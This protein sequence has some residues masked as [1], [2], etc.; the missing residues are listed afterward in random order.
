MIAYIYRPKR[1]RNG[2]LV[3][4]RIWR[5]R[6]KL[7][8]DVK[9]RDISL[10][11]ADKQTAEQKLRDSIRDQE[12]ESVGLLA[13]S[14]QRKTFQSPLAELVGGYVADLKALGR[15]ADHVRHVDKRLLRL[16]RECKWQNLREVTADSFLRWRAEQKQAPKTINEYQAALSALFTW[17]RKQN[18]VAAN[19]FEIVSKVD[20]RGKESFHR[21]ALNDDEARQLLAGPR[22]SL[23]L[24]ALHTGLRRGEINALRWGDL[25]LDVA[26]PFYAVPVAKSK[27]RKEQPRPLHHELVRELQAMKSAG[28]VTPDT[29]VFPEQVPA[30]KVIRADFK[31]AGIPL[32]DER[33]HRV[34]FHALR[35]TYITRL[36][37]AGVS[38]R[39]AM[40]LARHSDMR[41]TMKTYTDAA[42]LPLA[43][44]VRGL[45]AFD[46]SHI[47]SQTLVADGPAVSPA[48][49]GLKSIKVG[50]TIGNIDE[51]HGLTPAVA[52]C[53]SEQTNGD[54]GFE[55]P[56][57]RHFLLG[58]QQMT[59]E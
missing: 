43:A 29:L 11:C 56:S 30:M 32:V 47:D 36:Q 46:D 23:Y 20:T 37:R 1:Q 16:I 14:A 6:L 3:S 58:N 52:I 24:L 7:N 26:N 13:P 18:R 54:W 38:P 15:S 17:L 34:D 48:V 50:E 5:A 33:G 59:P 45:P 51:S 25:H 41:L 35:M 27:S 9:A 28:K 42:Q 19:P 10:N 40:E 4:S 31:T 57:L 12:R 2:K 39:E 55:S 22:R 8:G 53:H 44:T 21:R 49:T